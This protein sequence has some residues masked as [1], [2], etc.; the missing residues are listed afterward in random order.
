MKA[1]YVGSFENRD[2]P[3]SLHYH[4][5]RH[6]HTAIMHRDYLK[7]PRD[8]LCQDQSFMPRSIARVQDKVLAMQRPNSSKLLF[9][10]HVYSNPEHCRFFVTGFS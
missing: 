3:R 6:Y 7:H 5:L 9:S 4:F 8:R 10:R 2:F 1:F